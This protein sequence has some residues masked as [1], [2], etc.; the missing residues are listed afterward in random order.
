MLCLF[1]MLAAELLLVEGFLICDVCVVWSSPQWVRS[2]H[3]TNT[4]LM[5]APNHS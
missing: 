3:C 5:E 4:G 1:P 2:E